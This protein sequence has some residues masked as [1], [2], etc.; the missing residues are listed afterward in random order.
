MAP[1]KAASPAAP[2]PGPAEEQPLKKKAKLAVASQ[3][4][5]SSSAASSAAAATGA[6][7]PQG[8]APAPA[9]AETGAPAEQQ[10]VEALSMA[11]LLEVKDS[12]GI[13]P[14]MQLWAT[15]IKTYVEREILVFCTEK[16]LAKLNMVVPKTSVLMFAP[17]GISAAPGAE[18]TA[19]REKCSTAICTIRYTAQACTRQR[20][21]SFRCRLSR[22]MILK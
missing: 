11:H 15:K 7:K 22:A 20:G 1:K 16:V 5:A 2:P 10:V 6:G 9:K 18:L 19:F 17:L 13:G 12:S 14:Q 4:V 21:P 8:D 3:V